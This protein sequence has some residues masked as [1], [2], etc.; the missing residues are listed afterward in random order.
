[1]KELPVIQTDRRG[2]LKTT[3]AVLCTLPLAALI[4]ACETDVTKFSGQELVIDLKTQPD[5]IPIGGAIQNLNPP[6][7]IIRLTDT[8]FLVVTSI[9]THQGCTVPLPG[10][11]GE[12]SADMICPCHGAKFDAKTGKVLREP[13]TP[14]TALKSYKYTYDAANNTL[15]IKY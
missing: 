12:E 7:N 10:D 14:I 9:C 13:G 11:N 3:C 1:M 5:L 15:K 4:Q 2:F 6:M 8:T